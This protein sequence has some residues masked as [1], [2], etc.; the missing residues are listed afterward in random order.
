MVQFISGAD[1]AYTEALSKGYGSYTVSGMRGVE[2]QEHVGVS[3][4]DIE[5]SHQPAIHNAE[6]DVQ[7][8]NVGFPVVPGKL[9]AVMLLVE[10]F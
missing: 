8:G 9:D 1:A 2:G 10:P 3:G 7:V 5:I 6:T 4:F